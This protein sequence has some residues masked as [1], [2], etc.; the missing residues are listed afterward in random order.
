MYS[1]VI[2]DDNKIVVDSIAKSID[3]ESLRCSVVDTAGNGID[4]IKIIS[5]AHPD[6]VITD[7]IMPGFNG[8]EM[9]GELKSANPNTK[10]IVITGYNNY[11]YARQSI[12]LGVFDF[13]LKPIDNDDLTKVVLE[14]IESI[15]SSSAIGEKTPA[16]IE[17][18]DKGSPEY[19]ICEI[20]TKIQNYSPLVREVINYI[21]VNIYHEISLKSAAD[22]FQVS[23]SH[24]SNLFKK[25]TGK[26]F[27]NYV[28]LVKLCRAKKLLKNP[29]N[30]V[31]EV[32]LMLGYTDYAYFYQV[33]KKV[34]GVPPSQL[35]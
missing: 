29:K 9:I 35:K 28:T 24:L 10:F 11:E 31:Y 1:V 23:T 20:I 15:K 34:F 12:K 26:S 33:F 17:N 3:W 22:A 21:D 27:I 25:E 13:I 4:G 7:I 14:A 19:A 18:T 30:K 6:I 16:N 5:E 2:I 32:G 8:L